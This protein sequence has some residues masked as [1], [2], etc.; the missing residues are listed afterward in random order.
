M[1]DDGGQAYM[2]VIEN[3]NARTAIRVAVPV[4]LTAAAVLCAL[5]ASDGRKYAVITVI[6][7]L[8]SLLL[9]LA[10]F[11]KR[12]IGSRRL[13]LGAVFI[14]LAVAGRFIPQI[15]PLTA[16][17]IIS[18]MFTGAETGFLVGAV[19]VLISNIFFGNGPWTPLQ[20]TA[21]GLIGFFGGV[22]SKPLKKSKIILAL[23]GVGCG[24]F[25]S[26]FMDIWTTCSATGSLQFSAYLNSVVAAIPFT[27]IY[28]VSNVIY[29][30][31]LTPPF[32]RKLD[33]IAEKYGL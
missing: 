5:F 11:D 2:T 17:V 19:S 29:L 15:K 16:V 23:F 31:L 1:Q 9:F 21:M 8:L 33:R 25:Y 28:S 14:T 13:V 3:K 6:A 26:M 10:G 20:M 18:G 32:Q 7:T 4:I 30:L 22:L 27:I 24:I 12:R